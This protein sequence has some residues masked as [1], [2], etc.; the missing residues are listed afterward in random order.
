VS[1]VDRQTPE[2]PEAPTPAEPRRRRRAARVLVLSLAS[3]V[4][5]L[6]LLVVAALI[7]LP[8]GW[9]REKVRARMIYEIERVSGGRSEIGAF[10]FDWSTMT[11]EVAPFV[12]RGTE[13]PGEEPLFQADSIKVGLRIVSMMKRDVDIASLV[14]EQPRVNILVDNNGITNFPRPKLDRPSG[15][16]P[17]ERLVDL[18]IAEITLK[19]GTLRYGDRRLP[20]D[21]RGRFLTASLGY[22][23]TGPSYR[24]ALTMGE[25]TVDAKPV[26]PV[27][28]A[29]DSRVALF[30]NSVR[31]ERALMTMKDTTVEAS[32]TVENFSTP[33]LDFDVRAN[34]T[35]AELGPPLRLPRPHTGDVTF[36]GKLTYS[37][38]DR[39]LIAGRVTGQHLAVK[40]DR[41]SIDE[42]SLTSDVRM[43]A[44]DV[45]L[46]DTTVHALDGVFRG[47]M[48]IRDFK[49]F[50]VNGSL[51]GVSIRSLARMAALEGSKLAGTMNGPVEVTGSF[52][53]G[54]RDIKAG[55]RFNVAATQDGIPVEGFVEAAYDQRRNE[56]QLGNSYLTLPSSRLDFR[57]TLGQQLQIRLESRNLNDLLPALELASRKAPDKLPLELKP[58]GS[59][60]F[61]G[62]VTGPLN[63]A[64]VAG[65]ATLT[66]FEV[67]GQHVQRLTASVVATASGLQ[68]GSFALAQDT[69]RATGSIDAALNGWRLEDSSAV[70]GTFKLTD[71]RIATLLANAGRKMPVDGVLSASV[72]LE[73][74]A[75][76]P[77]ATLNLTVEKPTLYGETFDRLRAQVNYEGAGVEVING[78]AEVGAARVLLDG[79]YRHPE[80]DWTNGTLQFDVRSEAWTLQNVANIRKLRPGLSG[81]FKLHASGVMSVRNGELFPQKINGNLDLANL[82]FEGRS[83]GNFSVDART[84]GHQADFKMGG[85]L[86]GSKIN[87]F[88][89]FELSGDYP[90]IAEFSFSPLTFSTAQDLLLAAQGRQPMPFDGYVAGRILFSGPVKKPELLRVRIELPTLQVVPARRAMTARQIAELALRNAEPVSVEYDG[91]SFQIRSAHMVGRDT[92]LRVSGVVN[93]KDKTPWDLRVDGTLNVGVLQDFN[94]DL[95]SSGA[96]V[97]QAT[98][99]GT[100]QE[101]R[102]NGRVELKNASFYLADFPNGLDNANGTIVFDDRRATIENLKAQTGGGDLSLNGFVSFGREFIYRLQASAD[103]VRIRY[104]EGVS[105][106]ANASLTLTGTGPNSLLSGT[107]T[108]L[109]AGFN[110]RTD[111]AGL[112]ATAPTPVA[113][114]ATRNEYLR[115]MQFDVRVET[116]PNLQFQTSLTQDV[117][118]EADLR[119]RGTPAKPVVLGRIVIS[120]GEIQFFGNKYSINRG[121]IGF[122]NPVRIEPVIDM[123]LETRVRGVLVNINFN[124]SLNKLNVSYRSDPP[125]QSAEIIALLAVGRT[126]GSNAALASGQT[127]SNQSFLSSSSNNLL[128]QA[129]AVPVS[130]RLQRFFGVSRLKIDPQLTGLS[131]VPQARLTIEQQI[132]RDVTLTYVTNVAQPNQQIIR[133]EWDLSRTWSVVAVREEN[134]LFGVD[135]LFKKRFR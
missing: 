73:G 19:N 12:L 79:S 36:A 100:M 119:V 28:V 62:A 59:A 132:S 94:Q 125:L 81:A 54:T 83:I 66:G 118:A 111:I 101:P 16:H 6:L 44:D 121:E 2:A 93:L 122:F 52:E 69:M 29:F 113:A 82:S 84:S 42:I 104:P 109:R 49:A 78:V 134:G 72:K 5:V 85:N 76:A 63:D 41:V 112:L 40:Q 92:D 13:P 105:T 98:V 11:A 21:V 95:V 37:S 75:K 27:T 115:G 70:S 124:G 33:K 68:A 14:I 34:G 4:A 117:Q 31:V 38:L 128:G 71:A 7:I 20:I 30:K 88:G 86:R 25:M 110:P 26:L 39:L 35:L 87:G 123:D 108:V 60:L 129:V 127:V 77:K 47:S 9:F 74:T 97:I 102:L 89:A 130:S 1:D 48:D 131:A 116:V 61:E 23:F 103:Q 91:T 107:V 32:G 24:G 106:T 50:K 53:K 133:L 96:A 135:F 80:N 15:K 18:A 56:L 46:R 65:T 10:R 55:G 57:G 51:T 22:D 114:P 3:L 64:R 17:I 8:S 120:Q 90:G 99:R 45:A 58:G 43:T 67:G 126:P